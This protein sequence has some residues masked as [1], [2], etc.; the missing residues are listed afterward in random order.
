[1]GS[2]LSADDHLRQK[3]QCVRVAAFAES[4]TEGIEKSVVIE[5]QCV[6]EPACLNTQDVLIEVRSSSVG[7]VDLI[8]TSGQYQHMPPLPYTP[9]LEYSGVVAWCGSDAEKAGLKVG[10]RVYVDGLLTGPRSPGEYQQYGGFA[11]FAVAPSLAVRKIPEGLSFDQACNLLGSYET[12][13]HCLVKCGGLKAGET[14]LIHGASGATGLAAV[15]IAKLLGATVIA[16]GRSDEKLAVVK[17]QGAD[18]IINCRSD[19]ENVSVRRF[20]DEVKALTGGNGV[21]VV[22]DGV[23]GD[24]SLESMRCVKF[25]ARFLIVGWASTPFVAKGKGQ[26]GAPNANMLPTNL[27]M[28]KGLQVLGCPAVIS[29][30]FDPTIR[31]ERLAAIMSWVEDGKIKPYVSHRF[32]LHDVKQALLAKWRGDVIGGCVLYMD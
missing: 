4:P 15:H 32:A 6:P 31:P 22:Y 10:D 3:P 29:T 8:M 25:G 9:G 12:A 1:M 2:V 27:I 23:G 5:S 14:V 28:M 17:E 20:R 26:R 30:Q 24:I 13:Y 16:T 11:N 7:W 18:H 21:D 19:D